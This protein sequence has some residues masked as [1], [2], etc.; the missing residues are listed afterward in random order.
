MWP[1]WNYLWCWKWI[2][3]YVHYHIQFS[4]RFLKSASF[5]TGLRWS[6]SLYYFPRTFSLTFLLHWSTFPCPNITLLE[7]L[8][9]YCA[10]TRGSPHI[11]FLFWFSYLFLDGSF[12]GKFVNSLFLLPSRGGDSFLSSWVWARLRNLFLA[13]RMSEW[14][15]SLY[16]LRSGLKRLWLSPWRL[17][18][19]LS[20]QLLGRKPAGTMKT[21]KQPAEGPHGRPGTEPRLEPQEWTWMRI[22]P[23]WI[24]EMTATSQKR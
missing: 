11:F 4:H 19:S 17:A 10:V 23:Q 7:W 5:H 13:K 15:H 14:W 1:I 16:P 3:F 22:P 21:L 18:C 24:L 20:I 8:K 9:L 6:S 12:K 2:Y